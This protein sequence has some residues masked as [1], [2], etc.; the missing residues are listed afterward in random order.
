MV[1]G[2]F[3]FV[4]EVTHQNYP[5]LATRTER[6]P[7]TDTTIDPRMVMPLKGAIKAGIQIGSAFDDLKRSIYYG[8]QKDPMAIMQK[9]GDV[10]FEAS[11][12][13][14]VLTPTQYRLMHAAFGLVTEAMEFLE[15]VSNHILDGVPI[16]PV[17][18]MEE[19]GDS[20]WYSAIPMNIFGFTVLQTLT[21][22][23]D[24]LRARYPDKFDMEKAINRDL[25]AERQVLEQA[26]Q[27]PATP[28]PTAL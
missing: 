21:A 27:A 20:S 14:L 10:G 17:N 6:I 24:K 23:I 25:G 22:N 26:A 19:L 3:N 9:I 13:P 28:P 7:T 4:S 15:T 12:N 5:Q 16:D 11:S 8:Q 1:P 18:L 2:H